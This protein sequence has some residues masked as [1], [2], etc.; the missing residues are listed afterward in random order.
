MDEGDVSPAD[1]KKDPY[2][3]SIPENLPALFD[4]ELED[5][6]EEYDVYPK[7]ARFKETNL[8]ENI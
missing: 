1:L 6:Q 3:D 5:E 7:H 4:E 2:P 8:E